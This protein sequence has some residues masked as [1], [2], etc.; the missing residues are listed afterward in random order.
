MDLR[1]LRKDLRVVAGESGFTAWDF[2]PEDPQDL[3]AAVV[4][5]PKSMVRMNRLI[6]QVEIPITFYA[7][8]ADPLD[9][10]ER[11]DLA[12]ST[13]LPNSFIDLLDFAAQ[14]E[15]ATAPSW[16]SVRF[17]SAGPYTRFALPGTVYA[18]GVEVILE[19]TA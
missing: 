12:L 8:L 10:T 7:S 6:T 15:G 5:A 17:V 1:A 3:P 14:Q 18:L 4:G 16:R 11:L 9:A 2:V 13:G 19:L